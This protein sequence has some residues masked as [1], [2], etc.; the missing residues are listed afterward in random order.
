MRCRTRDST[1]HGRY[2]GNESSNCMLDA[3]TITNEGCD[4]IQFQVTPN[5]A[6]HAYK[7]RFLLIAIAAATLS[8]PAEQRGNDRK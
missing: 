1:L 6:E 2:F 8:R 5:S 3:K 7:Q 4:E